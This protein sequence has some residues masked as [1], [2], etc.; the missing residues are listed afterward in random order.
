MSAF[1]AALRDYRYARRA[2]TESVS[3]ES[4]GNDETAY[5]SGIPGSSGGWRTRVLPR[6]PESERWEVICEFGDD[7]D[8]PT[9][10]E[11]RF[12]G[13]WRD[14]ND[15]VESVGSALSSIDWADGEAYQQMIAACGEAPA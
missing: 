8:H 14:L 2:V 7:K 13:D 15:V 3:S 5:D 1:S 11:R 6:S 9:R 12:I 10:V 4:I